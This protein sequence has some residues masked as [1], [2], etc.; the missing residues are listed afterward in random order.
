MEH[1]GWS[2]EVFNVILHPEIYQFSLKRRY[3][4]IDNQQTNTVGVLS[5][6]YLSIYL[7]VDMLDS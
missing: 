6:I 5:S 1:F 3:I 4:V 2:K 7:T